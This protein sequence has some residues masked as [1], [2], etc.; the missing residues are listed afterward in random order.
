MFNFLDMNIRTNRSVIGRLRSCFV[1]S[2][3]VRDQHRLLLSVLYRSKLN[4]QDVARDRILG[5]Y[6]IYWK[7][8]ERLVHS[9]ILY[10]QFFR[11]MVWLYF[12]DSSLYVLI[13]YIQ[14]SIKLKKT[15]LFYCKNRII[16]LIT[17]LLSCCIIKFIT[18]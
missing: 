1:I 9:K 7:K 14:I 3:Y 18:L 13:Y 15:F 6:S 16:K 11:L 10:N 2:K 12:T 17:C 5:I 8:I 4:I